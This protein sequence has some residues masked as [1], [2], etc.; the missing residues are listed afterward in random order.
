[1]HPAG[2]FAFSIILLEV[3]IQAGL[4]LRVILRRLPTGIATSWLVLILVFPVAGAI[5]Y[6]FVGESRVGRR[7]LA[8]ER[9]IHPAYHQY[10][11]RLRARMRHIPRE[12]STMDARLARE[13]EAATGLPALGGNSL[14]FLPG[15]TEVL[16]S[17]VQA[18]DAADHAVF[19]EFFIWHTAGLVHEVEAAL[20]RAAERGVAC[21]VLVDAVGSRS[22]LKSESCGRLREAGV[23]VEPALPATLGRTPI[24]RRVDHRN[25]RKLAVIDEATAFVGSMNMADPAH[26]K[27][28][29]GVGQWIDLMA[30]VRG[31]IVELYTLL[32]ATDWEMEAGEGLAEL[33][34]TLEARSFEPSGEMS[35]QIAPSGPGL[36]L[37]TMHAI[38]LSA[39]YA[40]EKTLTITTPYFVPDQPVVTALQSAA[41]RGVR[42]TIIVPARSDTHLTHHAGRAFFQDL[43]DTGVHIAEFRGGLL[44]TKSIVVDE[45][46]ALFG[47]VNLDPRSFWL[48]FELTT[49]A[50]EDDIARALHARQKEYLKHCTFVDAEAWR[51]RPIYRKLACDVAQLFAPLL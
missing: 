36:E 38:V 34:E 22:F 19:L 43:L 49:I 14:E 31:P 42:V 5:A 2:W 20:R 45:E 23:R 29:A 16:R 21:R 3:L 35:V 39:I 51:R 26:F 18:I 50:Y 48:N 25:H 28:S 1:M 11:R 33:R 15:A 37:G 7:R 46:I 24:L 27:P 32:A 13:V 17:I 40:A 47:T 4:A 9:S 12:L 44:H 41:R 10:L 8:R 30:L 6:L